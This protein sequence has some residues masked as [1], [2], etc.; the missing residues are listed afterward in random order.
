MKLEP[1]KNYEDIK[2]KCYSKNVKGIIEEFLN[3][4]VKA[5]EIH[6]NDL[7]YKDSASCAGAFY[8]SA[9]RQLYPITVVKKGDHV[10]LINNSI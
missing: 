7:E 5:V 9:K 10:Y 4:N 8:K 1:I 6:F 3:M 2:P